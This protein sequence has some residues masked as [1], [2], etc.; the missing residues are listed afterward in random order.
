MP[1]WRWVLDAM[2]SNLV[3]SSTIAC[4]PQVKHTHA[5]FGDLLLEIWPGDAWR[6]GFE[7]KR[8]VEN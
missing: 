2:E 1:G 5:L 3:D 4:A 6:Q 8:T 7:R